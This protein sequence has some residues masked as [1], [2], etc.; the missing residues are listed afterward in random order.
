MRN[1][2]NSVLKSKSENII[3]LKKVEMPMPVPRLVRR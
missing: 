3:T 1:G 2:V